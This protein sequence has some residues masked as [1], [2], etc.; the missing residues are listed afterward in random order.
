MQIQPR[1]VALALLHP[2]ALGQ[3]KRGRG[4]RALSIRLKAFRQQRQFV[5]PL[6]LPFCAQL[7]GKPP[8]N[9]KPDLAQVR[10]FVD[11]D[12]PAGNGTADAHP[13]AGIDWNFVLS[14]LTLALSVGAICILFFAM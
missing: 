6:S 4:R 13:M 8:V 9:D 12:Q 14:A 11:L 3:W 5:S 10:L 7:H 1:M 2:I